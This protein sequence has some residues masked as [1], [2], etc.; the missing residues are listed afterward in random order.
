MACPTYWLL[1]PW[2][3]C[4]LGSPQEIEVK[5]KRAEG[6]PV[7]LYYL[8]DLSYSMKDDL[9]KVKNLGGQLLEALK[10]VTKSIQIGEPTIFCFAYFELIA[11]NLVA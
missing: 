11:Q 2:L 5:F 1:I 8:M 3:F 9:E 4:V 6:Y 7:D 10:S